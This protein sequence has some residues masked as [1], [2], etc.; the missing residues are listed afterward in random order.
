M[1]KEISANNLSEIL[2]IFDLTHLI[3][4]DTLDCLN[5]LDLSKLS[6]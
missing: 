1:T 5:E 4:K 6:N 2:I 3:I